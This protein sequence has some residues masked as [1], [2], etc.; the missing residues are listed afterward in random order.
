MTLS[1]CELQDGRECYHWWSYK[2]EEVVETAPTLHCIALL[3]LAR[4]K[5]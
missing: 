3:L 1:C 4:G 2:I 5:D